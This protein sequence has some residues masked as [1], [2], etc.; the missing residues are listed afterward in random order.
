MLYMFA[1]S[2]H[3]NYM[4]YLLET[5]I[6]LELELS[7]VLKEALL[8]CMLFNLVGLAGHFEKGDYI[9]EFF[10]RLLEAVSKHKNAQ[11]NHN[12]IRNIISRDLHHIA[13]LKHAWRIGT[14]MAQKSLKHSAYRA[15]ELHT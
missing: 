9:V 5:I 15:E 2:T 12:F 7:A 14:G 10:N 4:N 13:E 8:L 1:G 11:F 6:N 3:S